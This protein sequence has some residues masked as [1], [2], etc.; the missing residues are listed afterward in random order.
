[1][2]IEDNAIPIYRQLAEK[3]CDDVLEK[4]YSVGE[5]MPS[6]RE[7]AAGLQVNVNTVQKAFDLLQQNGIIYK[8]RGVGYYV[9]LDA[10]NLIAQTR[11]ANFV[12]EILPSIFSTMQSLNISIEDIVNYHKQSKNK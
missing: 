7:I 6:M 3:V 1:M 4:K 10:Y 9:S 11:K 2:I 8:E 12:N 5:R